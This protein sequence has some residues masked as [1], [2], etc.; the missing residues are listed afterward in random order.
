MREDFWQ[1]NPTHKL[2]MATNHKPV[3]R[4]TDLGIW[5]R[6]RLV[7]F[8]VSIPT[9]EQDTEL[10]NKLILELP[11]ILNWAIEG[12]RQWQTSG[13]E[14]PPQVTDATK[15]YRNES[16]HIAQFLEESTITGEAYSIKASAL[17]QTY[18]NWGGHLTN[19]AFGKEIKDRFEYK[20][21]NTG[22]FYMGIGVP[23]E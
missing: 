18:D 14:D 23:N 3:I 17:F 13:L 2:W 19:T 10:T 15:Q 20:R 1:F 6:L 8:E 4:G 12:C 16:D 11:G 9:E 22:V 21:R 7:P 5:R